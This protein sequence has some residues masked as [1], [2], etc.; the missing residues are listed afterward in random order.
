MSTDRKRRR[1]AQCQGSATAT[2]EDTN[3][4]FQLTSSA[5]QFYD[6][7]V[8]LVSSDLQNSKDLRELGPI[9]EQ[10]AITLIRRLRDTGYSV[11]ALSHLIKGKFNPDRDSATKAVPWNFDPSSYSKYGIHDGKKMKI[12]K[13]LNVNIEAD[14]GDF[15]SNVATDTV[16]TALKTYDIIAMSPQNETSF[17]SICT[18]SNLF[19]CD[20]ITLDYTS[21]R[22]GIQLPYKIKTTDIKAAANRGLIFELPYG[23]AII[24]PSKRKAFVQTARLF[25]NAIVGIKDDTTRN[26]PKIIISSGGRVFENHDYGVM[27]L[28]SPHDMI[29]FANVVLG[30]QQKLSR[31]AFCNNALCAIQRGWNRS[32]GKVASS[33]V[34]SLKKGRDVPLNFEVIDSPPD[35]LIVKSTPDVDEEEA[36]DEEHTQK[37]EGI[38]NN[39][40]SHNERDS[41]D[42]DDDEDFLK[43]S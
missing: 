25:L 20:I 32:H 34:V 31:D 40:E 35:G 43:L 6:L 19:Y 17:T 12:F 15:C 11:I 24:D 36:D 21:G 1:K 39:I 33:S 5:A 42:N 22:G 27:A 14:F 2:A 41:D 10:N 3:K 18:M 30:F 28:R 13:R 16:T 38:V 7:D 23:P 29:N 37:V 9:E 8:P 4:S 26:P